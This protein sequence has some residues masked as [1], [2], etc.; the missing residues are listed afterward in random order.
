M[1]QRPLTNTSSLKITAAYYSCAYILPDVVTPLVFPGPPGL[2]KQ[3]KPDDKD[4]YDDSKE[5]T[6]PGKY[7]VLAKNVCTQASPKVNIF[8]NLEFYCLIV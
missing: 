2:S 8:I 1:F 6:G 5:P 7:Y 4:D 3:T